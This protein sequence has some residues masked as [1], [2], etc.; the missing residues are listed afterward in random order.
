[1]PVARGLLLLK[2]KERRGQPARLSEKTGAGSGG[3]RSLEAC[4]VPIRGS[5]E[6]GPFPGVEVRGRMSATCQLVKLDR[7]ERMTSGGAH[8]KEATISPRAPPLSRDPPAIDI[9]ADRWVTLD[10]F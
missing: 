8:G 4:E 5:D 7:N 10:S 9:R 2:Q 3:G 1:M 6:I